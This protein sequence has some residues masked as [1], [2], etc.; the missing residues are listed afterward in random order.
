MKFG[1]YI[2]THTCICS[3]TLVNEHKRHKEKDKI[4][5]DILFHQ[6]YFQSYQSNVIMRGLE[7]WLCGQEHLS[8]LQR[9]WQ[10]ITIH[11]SSSRESGT[12]S[13]LL[14][15]PGHTHMLRINSCNHIHIKYQ[16]NRYHFKCN[17]EM[18][19]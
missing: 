12:L 14:W 1:L 7:K 18:L 13:W 5:F 6:E 8:F 17:Y 19:P 15:A 10:L 11:Y 2:H 16:K 3:C 4:H 9:T